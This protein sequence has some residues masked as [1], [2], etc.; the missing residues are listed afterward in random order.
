[1]RILQISSAASFAG[2]ER[3]FVDLTN[4]L[5]ARG[6]ELYAAV[7]PNS[8]LIPQLQIPPDN[9]KIVALRNA[10]DVVSAHQ[11]ESLVEQQR[12]DVV[13][14]HMA[15]DYSLAAYATRR[16]STTKFVVTRHVL[17]PLN[18]F[19]KRTLAHASRVIAVSEA[20]AKCLKS[21]ALVPP[22]KIAVI[23]N[24][25]DVQR[26]RQARG[27][28]AYRA[29]LGVPD[30]CKLI[31]TI[32]E[33]RRLKRH[34]DF[35]KA[36]AIVARDNP[37]AYFVLAGSPT[38]SDAVERTSLEQLVDKLGLSERFRFLGWLDDSAALLGSLDVFVSASETESFGL[39][40]AEAMASGAVVVATA[41]EGAREIISEGETGLVVPIGAVDQMAT[42]ITAL[43]TDDRRRREF[44]ARG[45]RRVAE[46]FSLERMVDETEKL[47]ESL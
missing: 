18:R 24:G 46:L 42:A 33:L 6:H 40:I 11:L 14:A 45:E 38:S 8:P 47:Y 9:I 13:H 19:H 43:L 15:R 27:R 41:T 12:I 4:A 36:A 3:H 29:T 35:I 31:G 32:G 25:I 2:G 5:A 39:V 37:S 34:D 28:T 30:D 10:F 26:F 1:M 20:T 44:A 21:L 16:N 7:R 22:E 23:R 17:F